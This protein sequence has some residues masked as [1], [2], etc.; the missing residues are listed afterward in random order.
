MACAT[1]VVATGTGGSGDYLRDGDNCVLFPAGDARGLADALQRLA[2]D[3][4]LRRSIV[5]SGIQTAGTFTTERTA[6]ELEEIHLEVAR[7]SRR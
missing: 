4:D 7:Q 6:R 1:P 2:E 5:A 3:D